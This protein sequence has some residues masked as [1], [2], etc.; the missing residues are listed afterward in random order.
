MPTSTPQ[1]QTLDIEAARAAK[2]RLRELHGEGEAGRID[3]GVDQVLRLWREDD[4]DAAAFSSFV[5][6]EFVPSG[7]LLD[8]TFQ[9][10]EFAFER[11]G[12]FMTSLLRDLR[13]GADVDDGPL[14]PID[15]RLSGYNPAAHLGDDLFATR[16][17]FV[18]LLNFP[19]TTL[20]ERLAQGEGWSRRQWAE[21]RMAEGFQTRV[22]AEVKQA[23]SAA[24]AASAAYV[25]G[26]NLY[27]HH[28]LTAD[29]RRLFPAGQRLISHWGL[30]DEL[31]AA[32]AEPGGL[33]KQRLLKVVFDRIVRQEIPA[34]VIENPR[35]DWTP[36]SNA[37]ARSTVE[38]AEL[39]AGR[40]A[41]PSTER[42][43]DERYRQWIGNFQAQRLADPYHKENPT[44][45]DRIFNL[46]REM[47]ES[48]VRELLESVLASPLRKSVAQSIADRLGRPLEPFDLWYV[49]F[50]PRGVH[51]EA[52]LDARVRERY[53]TTDAFARDVPRLLREMGFSAQRA[54]F[55]ADQIVVE[56]S[57]GAGHAYGGTR[58]DDKVLLRTRVGRDGMGYQGYN[59]ALHE[60]GH[61]VE[62]VFSTITIDHT[63]LQGV[64]NTAFSE[65]M[66]FYFQNKDL[67]LLG[68]A[69]PGDEAAHL[70]AL[71]TFWA[72]RE[73]GGVALVDV[74]AWRWLYDHPDSTPAEFREAVLTIARDV[75]NRY[76]AD[77]L[78]RSDETLLVVYSHMV[79]RALYIPDYPLGHVIAFQIERYFHGFEGPVGEEL[80]R[81]LK[82]GK[83]TPDAWMRQAVG[84][85]VSAEPLLAAT[86]AALSAL[87]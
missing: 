79:N 36:E 80:E 38:D 68:F 27:T 82:I 87:P 28:V 47:P 4:G 70:N 62:Q 45:M 66:A 61:N 9:R 14:L 21:V 13:R 12:G 75:W 73:I 5:E 84:S 53:P 37:V 18:V 83:L 39:P 48:E 3:R 78:G 52:E 69:G 29:G 26:Y 34:A 43:E 71:D 16:I 40:P 2:G 77:V 44:Y 25:N 60:L 19:L 33:E 51:A 10:L 57:R 24:R 63:E 7:E 74:D 85:S 67:E 23:S 81:I 35:L 17:A 11:L 42:E 56:P 8:R 41:E 6:S 50:K 15:T 46:A 55:V 30:R 72:T 86:E 76:F 59:T 49:G 20:E 32:Y 31:K 64:P 54:R 65:A 1:S 58:R 22:P